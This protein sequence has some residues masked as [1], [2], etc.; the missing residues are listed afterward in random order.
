MLSLRRGGQ[1]VSYISRFAWRRDLAG[2]PPTRRTHLERA[3]NVAT[4]V[5]SLAATFALCLGY[6]Q[7]HTTQELTRETLQLQLDALEHGRESKAIDLFLK[8][9]EVQQGIN[10]PAVSTSEEVKFWQQNLAITITESI[11]KLTENDQG[12]MATVAFM[13]REQRDFLEKHGLDCSTFLPSFIEFVNNELGE[14]VCTPR[15]ASKT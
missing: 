4:I 1:N 13:L 5:A 7:F 2:S 15:D 14:D 6:L 12:W 8:F 3:A 11:Y 9:N 10:N